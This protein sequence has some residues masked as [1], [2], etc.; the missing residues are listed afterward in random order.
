MKYHELSDKAK[1][2]AVEWM[3]RCCS[4]GFDGEF[5]IE[6]W[7]SL[8]GCLGFHGIK[9][10]WSGFWSQGDGACFQAKWSIDWVEWDHIP[11]YTNEKRAKELVI[12]PEKVRGLY[13]LLS[14]IE[15]DDGM[16]DYES[17]IV[18]KCALTH[19]GLYNHENSIGFD[20]DTSAVYPTDEAKD[21][22]EDWCKDMMRMIYK[23]LEAEYEWVT[24]EEYAVEAIELGE[25]NFNEEGEVK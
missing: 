11:N 17:P 8:L 2:K 9:I 18:T 6:D 13:K 19:R 21:E 7:K 14:T 24:G 23:D 22:F 5:V 16:N 3:Q 4:E 12:Y 20:F 1:C 25:Y 15:D 10:Y